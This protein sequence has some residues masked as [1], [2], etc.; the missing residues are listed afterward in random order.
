MILLP[1]RINMILLSATIDKPEEFA[2]WLGDL[3]QKPI[4]LITK[5]IMIILSFP[6]E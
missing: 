4:N 6:I 2:S 3:K 1:S 5:N